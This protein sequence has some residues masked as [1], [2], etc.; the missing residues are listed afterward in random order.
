MRRS[1]RRVA[2]RFRRMDLMT[3]PWLLMNELLP[4]KRLRKPPL[5]PPAG[6]RH[7]VDFVAQLRFHLPADEAAADQ[8]GPP[9]RGGHSQPRRGTHRRSLGCGGEFE[10]DVV[11]PADLHDGRVTGS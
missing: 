3:S 2:R 4:P 7:P 10:T 5:V 1:C 11:R 8:E 6:A 9:A